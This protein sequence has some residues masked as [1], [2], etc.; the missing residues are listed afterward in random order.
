MHFQKKTHHVPYIFAKYTVHFCKTHHVPCAFAKYTV[1][2][3]KN[4][5]ALGQV[6][7]GVIQKHNTHRASGPPEWVVQVLQKRPAA[8][9]RNQGTAT[10][11]SIWSSWS[12]AGFDWIAGILRSL[13]TAL[14]CKGCCG[15]V[16]EVRERGRVRRAM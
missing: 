4:T 6:R 11:G 14:W 5:Y 9:I 7:K 10:A 1:H 8:V 16:G 13:L 3:H 15:N 2:F 12:G